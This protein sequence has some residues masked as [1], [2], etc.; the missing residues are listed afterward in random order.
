M[1]LKQSRHYGYGSVDPLLSEVATANCHGK[2]YCITQT[3]MSVISAYRLLFCR[4]K[5]IF[6]IGN[7]PDVQSLVTIFGEFLISVKFCQHIG[8]CLLC[9]VSLH[10]YGDS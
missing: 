1:K 2:A 3:E 6:T 5:L 7:T 4:N 10:H 8:C 9:M